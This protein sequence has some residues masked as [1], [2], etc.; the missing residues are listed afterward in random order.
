MVSAAVLY[1]LCVGVAIFAGLML[2]VSRGRRHGNPPPPA[3]PK[4]PPPPSPPPAADDIRSIIRSMEAAPAYKLPHDAGPAVL[5]M[6]RVLKDASRIGAAVDEPEGSRYLQI[7]DTL[8][9]QL[10][11]AVERAFPGISQKQPD[12]PEA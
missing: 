4:P 3:G 1:G 2:I 6:Y 8:A 10:T 7:S 11:D 12:F 5:S 9:R